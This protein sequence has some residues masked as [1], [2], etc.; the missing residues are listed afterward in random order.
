MGFFSN[1]NSEQQKIVQL[2]KI[3]GELVDEIEEL[4]SQILNQENQTSSG[5]TLN[6]KQQAELEIVQVLLK[7]YKS[8]VGFVQ[9]IMQA[10][11]E[12][13]S[14]AGELNAKTGKRIVTV[15]Q[16]GETINSSIATIAEEAMNFYLH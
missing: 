11:V 13:L 10:S 2:E 14:E 3:N 9:S 7:S 12:A 16:E 6:A 1:C 15:Q 8:G 4:K 5:Q